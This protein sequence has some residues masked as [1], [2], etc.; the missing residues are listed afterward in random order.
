VVAGTVVYVFGIMVSGPTLYAFPAKKP[1]DVKG[2]YIGASQAAFALGQAIGPGIGTL[3][4]GRLG[5]GIWAV[6]GV[7]GLL[8]A[9]CAVIG[10]LDR[11]EG[12]PRAAASGG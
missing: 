7:V 10:M 3:S 9:A 4:W 6:C 12:Q 2:R 5:N 11:R 8:S 1:A